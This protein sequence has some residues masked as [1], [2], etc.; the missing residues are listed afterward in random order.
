MWQE[1]LSD[2][3]DAMPRTCDV[4]SSSYGTVWSRHGIRKK[5]RHLAWCGVSMW[6]M[7]STDSGKIDEVFFWKPKD[8]RVEGLH[9]H[10]VRTITAVDVC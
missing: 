9:E 10:Q 8:C 1:N 3:G 7:E 6:P 5:V 4:L 2:T